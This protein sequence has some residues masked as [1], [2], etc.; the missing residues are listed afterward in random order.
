MS[1]RYD[2]QRFVTAQGE[3]RTYDTAVAELRA[4]RKRTHWMWFVFPQVA[5][6][7]QS[8]I[9]RMYAISSVAEAQAYLAHPV[10]GARLRECA[11]ILTELKGH[12]AQEVFGEVD[13]M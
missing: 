4:A 11:R 10:L 2:L 9:S 6:L 3:G 12:T 13:A 8:F 7:G 1:D 5:G